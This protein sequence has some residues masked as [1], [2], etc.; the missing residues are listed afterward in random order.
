MSVQEE[1]NRFQSFISLLLKWSIKIHC[2]MRY[3][4]VYRFKLVTIPAYEFKCIHL[5]GHLNFD[6]RH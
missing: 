3:R 1:Y 5:K 2:T 6:R 4:M